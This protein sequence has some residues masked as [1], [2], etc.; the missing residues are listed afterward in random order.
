MQDPYNHVKLI[1]VLITKTLYHICMPKKGCEVL[2]PDCSRSPV[3]IYIN[4]QHGQ[5][6]II[7]FLR[8]TEFSIK[9]M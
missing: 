8:M 4:H 6:D 2:I 3:F 9:C 5:T 7:W 1:K